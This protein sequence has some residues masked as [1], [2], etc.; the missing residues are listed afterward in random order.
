MF[1]YQIHQIRRFVDRRSSLD[2]EMFHPFFLDQISTI[3]KDF[4]WLGALLGDQ[5]CISSGKDGDDV[6]LQL[7]ISTTTRLAL[8]SSYATG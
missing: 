5:F 6:S 8:S 2:V 7:T 4:A 1:V 3:I